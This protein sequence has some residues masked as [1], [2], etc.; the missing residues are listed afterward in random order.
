MRALFCL[1]LLLCLFSCGKSNKV[2]TSRD[3]PGDAAVYYARCIV[4]EKYDEYIQAMQS[5]D[6][7]SED[8]KNKMKILV[9]Q[10]VRQRRSQQ[11]SCVEIECLHADIKYDGSYANTFLRLRYAGD[12][13]ET[14]MLPLVWSDGRWR[15]R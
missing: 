10:M 8:Y 3:N 11:D 15:L 14:V 5:C 9:K 7:A 1:F 12:S 13:T 2:L 4:E 6:S